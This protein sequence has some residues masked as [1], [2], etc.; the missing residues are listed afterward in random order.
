MVWAAGRFPGE[1]YQNIGITG[2]SIHLIDQFQMGSIF[3]KVLLVAT[4]VWICHT[5]LRY[6]KAQET[7]V[8]RDVNQPIK[9]RHKDISGY[10]AE[11]KRGH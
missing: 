11:T 8:K 10:D 2:A 3:W 6:R 4:D 5:N 1:Q 9:K 7:R